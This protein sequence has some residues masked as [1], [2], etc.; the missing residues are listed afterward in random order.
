MSTTFNF[1]RLYVPGNYLS[2]EITN[3]FHT[4]LLLVFRNGTHPPFGQIEGETVRSRFFPPAEPFLLGLW[5]DFKNFGERV[6]IFVE[7]FRRL[8]RR[9]PR[10]KQGELLDVILSRRKRNLMSVEGAFDDL[11]VE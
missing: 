6:A 11:I 7:E 3:N 4:A 9:E 5:N 2:Q 1:P 8:V 10:G